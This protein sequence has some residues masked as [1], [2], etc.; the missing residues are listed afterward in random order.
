[1]LEECEDA[2][3]RRKELLD[4]QLAKLKGIDSFFDLT[5]T[6]LDGNPYPFS[7]LKGKVTV[8]VNVASF[9]GFTEAS[10][11]GLVEL[12][13]TVD[14]D[15]VRILAFPCNQFEEQ[16]PGTAEEIKDFATSKGVEF[17]MMQKIDVNGPDT[18]PVYVYLK[19]QTTVPTIDWNFGTYFLVSP[20]GVVAEYTGVAPHH[21]IPFIYELMGKEEL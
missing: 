14:R 17:Q 8:I 11:R 1:M 3:E 4:A 19:H 9:C 16:E 13:S 10:Y 7:Q 21:L 6:D 5:S 18:D 20:E 15:A 12:W 2:C